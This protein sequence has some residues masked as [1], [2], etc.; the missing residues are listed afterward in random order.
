[1][2]KKKRKKGLIIVLSLFGA[3]IIGA[4]YFALDYY[5]TYKHENI[6]E[7]GLI[8]H[9]SSKY[10]YDH[11][12]AH[13][14]EQEGFINWKRFEKAAKHE[15]LAS[16]FKPGRYV[17]PGGSTNEFIIRSI[18]NNWQTPLNITLSGRMRN[19]ERIARNLGRQFDA[20][21]SDFMAILNDDLFRDSLG[22]SQESYLAMFIPN[23]YEMYW[24]T[25][26]R[27]VLLR[28]KK[29]Y[30]TFWNESRLE[31]AKK[32]NMTP[33]EVSTLASIVVE[34]SNYV[35]EQPTIAGVYMNRLKK[36]IKLQADPTVVFAVNDPDLRR[37]L[38]S[39]LKIDSPYNTYKY[40]GLPPGPIAV[41]SISAID[42]V[43]NYEKHNY[44]YFCAHP[45]FNGSHN[46]AVTYNEH[47]RNAREYRKALER[48]NTDKG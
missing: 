23:T 41:P 48:R 10:D 25:S 37:V 27:N 42:A 6:S 38:N 36:G 47:L 43:L 28:L 5:L 39:H 45:D 16:S 12:M 40:A 22:F 35:P 34:E 33:F 20:D 29:E 46:F 17:F 31:K 30:D 8:V 4:A 11:M 13:L 26:P 7:E 1:M 3:I 14:S 9:I 2:E 18:A 15:D 24:T 19:K 32:I 21:S 44:I